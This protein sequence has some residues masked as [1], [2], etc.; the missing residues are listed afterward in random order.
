MAVAWNRPGIECP[1]SLPAERVT[2][3]SSCCASV[4]GKTWLFPCVAEG[5]SLRTG[6]FRYSLGRPDTSPWSSSD[7]LGSPAR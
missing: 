4:S 5:V 6:V 2:A 1:T 3:L 7:G